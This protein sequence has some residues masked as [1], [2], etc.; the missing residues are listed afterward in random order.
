MELAI[1]AVAF[2]AFIMAHALSARQRHPHRP[3]PQLLHH[4]RE[5]P[6]GPVFRCLA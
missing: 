2:G 6:P 5:G 1:A 4:E 3:P